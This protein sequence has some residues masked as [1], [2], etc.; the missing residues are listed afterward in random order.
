MARELGLEADG[1][2]LEGREPVGQV[3]GRGAGLRNVV[4]RWAWRPGDGATVFGSDTGTA[5]QEQIGR[6][7]LRDLVLFDENK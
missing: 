1:E 5:K 3:A 6:I 7:R 4:V 2:A